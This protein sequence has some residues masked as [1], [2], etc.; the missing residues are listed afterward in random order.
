MEHPLG[1]IAGIALVNLGVGVPR[2]LDG[3]VVEDGVLTS[4]AVNLICG[5]MAP[6]IL[7]IY[8]ANRLLAR[9]EDGE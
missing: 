3:S 9:G 2:L 5:A 6:V 7:V 4:G 1:Y 8:M